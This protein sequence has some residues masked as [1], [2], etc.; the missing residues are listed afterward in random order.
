MLTESIGARYKTAEF[1]RYPGNTA[2]IDLDLESVSGLGP[3]DA[4]IV[5]SD[6]ADRTVELNNS[7]VTFG[8]L[9]G[10]DPVF[11]IRTTRIEVAAGSSS[12]IE[13]VVLYVD[14]WGT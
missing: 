12:D 5:S 7:G 3:A 1:F 2:A 6:G 4:V 14:R 8:V 13:I 11:E 9:D 10:R